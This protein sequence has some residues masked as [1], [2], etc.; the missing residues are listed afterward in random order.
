MVSGLSAGI[1]A[2]GKNG[3]VAKVTGLGAGYSFLGFGSGLHA[4]NPTKK[5]LSKNTCFISIFQ[6]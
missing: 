4:M 5:R 6:D 3:F 1:T 2:G